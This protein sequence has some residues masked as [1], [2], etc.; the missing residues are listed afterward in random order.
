MN[1]SKNE[2]STGQTEAQA[3]KERELFEG[4][5]QVKQFP[6]DLSDEPVDASR[7]K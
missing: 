3:A 5:R 1:G 6:I 4:L 2:Q 7:Q